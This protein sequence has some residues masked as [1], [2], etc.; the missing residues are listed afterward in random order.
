MKKLGCGAGRW[1]LLSF[2]V[3]AALV[4][5]QAAW[6]VSGETS[7]T[8]GISSAKKDNC[9]KLRCILQGKPSSCVPQT[10]S[11]DVIFA[12]N[13]DRSTAGGRKPCDIFSLNTLVRGEA[14]AFCADTVPSVRLADP[15][16]PALEL[17]RT[18]NSTSYGVNT[19]MV[20]PPLPATGTLP[21]N[22]VDVVCSTFAPSSSAVGKSAAQGIRACRQVIKCPSGTC[23]PPPPPCNDDGQ[24]NALIKTFRDDTACSILK[25]QLAATITGNQAPDVSHALFFP[26]NQKVGASGATGLFVC[27]G[28]T[29]KCGAPA[30]ADNPGGSQ[31]DYQID[32]GVNWT[33]VCSYVKT[34]T[35]TYKYVCR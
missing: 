19:G 13:A 24:N 32:Y 29:W 5:S 18:L 3:A 12:C 9:D 30:G 22:T 16:D 23:D 28:Y 27:P 20:L 14:L 21:T 7:N 35:G 6:A 25:Q 11:A 10:P 15:N 17:G 8:L 31:V 1:L 4:F 2:I 33:P 26:F 34:V